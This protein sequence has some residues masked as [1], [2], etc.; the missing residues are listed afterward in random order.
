MNIDSSSIV[1]ESTRRCASRRAAPRSSDYGSVVLVPGAA[2]EETLTSL[3]ERARSGDS[4]AWNTL[5]ERLQRVVWKVTYSFQLTTE[6]REE[7]F[8]NT[9][10]RLL[11][12][13][14]TV[15]DPEFL[16]GW[17]ATTARRES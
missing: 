6:D 12:K 8:Q 15:L 9:W 2:A 17:L 11:K 7:A 10:E 5:V 4:R 16:P 1:I 14:A 13:I 3:V